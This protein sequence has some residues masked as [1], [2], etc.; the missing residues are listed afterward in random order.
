M[1]IHGPPLLSIKNIF[2]IRA[3]VVEL[4]LRKMERKMLEDGD[5]KN[6]QLP[7]GYD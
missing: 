1:A 4:N 2:A 3:D 5:P 7:S 6:S